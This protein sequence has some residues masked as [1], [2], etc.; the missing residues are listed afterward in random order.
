[1]F[2]FSARGTSAETVSSLRKIPDTQMGSDPLGIA[3]RDLLA[4]TIEGAPEPLGRYLVTASGD[5]QPEFGPVV[6]HVNVRSD[7]LTRQDPPT[8]LNLPLKLKSE[9][10]I[11]EL[12]DLQRLE[13]MQPREL[14]SPY[15]GKDAPGDIPD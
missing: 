3:I 7:D 5:G 4:R 8:G 12:D 1:M 14:Q 13:R 10:G 15:P 2:S 6:L 9:P 11:P